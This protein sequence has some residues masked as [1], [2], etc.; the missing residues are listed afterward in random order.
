MTSS[1]R[2]RTGD[3]PLPRLSLRR[4]GAPHYV[5]SRCATWDFQDFGDLPDGH[6]VKHQAAP[7]VRGSASGRGSSALSSWAGGCRRRTGRWGAGYADGLEDVL[8][9]LLSDIDQVKVDALTGAD[10]V[11]ALG[12]GIIAAPGMLLGPIRLCECGVAS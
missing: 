5:G 10:Q 7:S 8:A 3:G 4:T 9:V 2:Y 1:R 6:Q 11:D 12:V